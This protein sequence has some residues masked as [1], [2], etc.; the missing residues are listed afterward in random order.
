MADDRHPPWV[1]PPGGACRL[2]P[3]GPALQ[4]PGQMVRR[5]H[6]RRRCCVPLF[7]VLQVAAVSH[8]PALRVQLHISRG[9]AACVASH[10]IQRRRSCSIRVHIGMLTASGAVLPFSCGLDA[11]VSC[12]CQPPRMSVSTHGCGQQRVSGAG[13]AACNTRRWTSRPAP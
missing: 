13:R 11:S 9:E 12:P 5:R 4:A 7:R 2:A 6:G 8:P 10:S 3:A 1:R